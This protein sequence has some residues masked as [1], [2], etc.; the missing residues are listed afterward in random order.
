L[1][2]AIEEAGHLTL[3]GIEHAGELSRRG[4][5]FPNRA[6]FVG[7]ALGVEK[8]PRIAASA[9]F[10]ISVEFEHEMYVR[11]ADVVTSFC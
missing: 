9:A 7:D 4:R 6:L 3:V 1:T 8:L 11:K 10:F 2:G 5:G